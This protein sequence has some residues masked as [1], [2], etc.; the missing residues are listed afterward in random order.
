MYHRNHWT[1]LQYQCVLIFAKA[2]CKKNNIYSIWDK[3][4]CLSN[5]DGRYYHI[6]ASGIFLSRFSQTIKYARCTFLEFN[7]WRHLLTSNCAFFLICPL[8]CSL[9]FI[10]CVHLGICNL[11]KRGN[12]LYRNIILWEA[13]FFLSGLSNVSVPQ[14]K[15]ILWHFHIWIFQWPFWLLRTCFKIC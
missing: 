10:N 6:W 4:Q 14:I 2:Q 15:E 7:F 12:I 5:I 3:N 11:L 9:L 13:D 1:S 8:S